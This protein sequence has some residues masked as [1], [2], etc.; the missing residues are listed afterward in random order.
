MRKRLL[1]REDAKGAKKAR[2]ILCGLCVFAVISFVF[3]TCAQAPVPPPEKVWISLGYSTLDQRPP[4]WKWLRTQCW[5]GKVLETL[6]P[7]LPKVGG[8]IV[9]VFD[10]ATCFYNTNIV[11]FRGRDKSALPNE[12]S[13]RQL[14]QAA[15]AQQIPVFLGVDVL[16]WRKSALPAAAATAPSPHRGEGRSEGT[17]DKDAEL[18]EL[19]DELSC[20]SSTGDAAAREGYFASPFHEKVQ[21]PLKGLVFELAKEFP[22][23]AGLAFDVRLSNREILGYSIA[24]REA[25]ILAV[26]VDP[27]YLLFASGGDKCMQESIQVWTDWRR[28]AM[29]A[30]VKTLVETYRSQ[31]K[32]GQILVSGFANYYSQGDIS[33]LRSTQ[34]WLSWTTSG[35]ADGLLLEGRWYAPHN[36]AVH[37]DSA[38]GLVRKLQAAQRREAEWPAL[39][40]AVGKA[41]GG[42][43]DFQADWTALK[44]RSPQLTS[45]L[46]VARSD[47]DL[48]T[49]LRLARGEWP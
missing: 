28:E 41:T 30:F 14:L 26:Q 34:D 36:E 17:N 15:R 42:R 29:E 23:A 6:K 22:D 21:E 19:N 10:D 7:I 45:V 16:G 37:F 40:V 4:D 44:S 5:E 2:R 9:P 33:H 46:L 31:K 35:L 18:F 38:T 39:P 11:P 47:A 20:G 32:E 13:L 43:T 48:Q 27:I 24:A 12:K 1:N 25:S 49:A 8:L 3:P